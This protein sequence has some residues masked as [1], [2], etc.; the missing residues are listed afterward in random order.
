M[1]LL[2]GAA[3]LLAG[4]P[5]MA[6]SYTVREATLDGGGG[7]V[8]GGGFV[9]TSSL[10]PGPVGT[11]RGGPYVLYSAFPSPLAGQAAIVIVHSPG[12]TAAAGQP[13]DITARIIANTDALQS[14]TLYYGSAASAPTA[15]PMTEDGDGY[16]ATIP[17]SAI[18]EAGLTYYF[19]AVDQGGTRVRAPRQGVYGLPVQFAGDGLRKSTAQPAGTAQTAY[20]L[21]SMPVQLDDPRPQ[22]VLG[23]DL[24]TLAS[25]AAYDP[26]TAR[27]FEPVGTIVPEFPQTNNF[28]LGR[29]FW[30]IVRD[31]GV[32]LDSGPGTALSMEAPFTIPLDAGWTFI[33][34]PFPVSVPVENLSRADGAEVRLY[35]YGADGYNTLDDPVTEMQ[36]FE[37]YAVFA[38]AQTSLTVRPPAAQAGGRSVRRKAAEGQATV[39]WRLR[40]RATSAA[41]GD[42]NNVAAVHPEATD[43]WDAQ[44]WPEPPPIG[45]GLRLAF[46]APEG[47]PANVV[48]SAD[49]R[50]P[51]ARGLTWPLTLAADAAGPV[52]LTVDGLAQVPAAFDVWLLDLSTRDSWNLR[53]T[54]TARIDVLSDGAERSLR[55]VAGTDAYVQRTLRD[56]NVLPLQYALRPPNPHPST[57]P[58]AFQVGLPAAERVSIEVYNILGQRLAV[59]KDDEPMTPGFH[60]V[61]WEAPRL[62]SGVY[63][64]RM[65]AGTFRKTQK[66]VRVQ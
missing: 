16:V 39:P 65:T 23:D 57:G 3:L 58:V 28:R 55:L 12:G 51:S 7:R 43:G 40:L 5:A 14:A 61:V 31:A 21:L 48:L 53:T 6:Q 13:R 38:E 19:E 24:P 33:G 17:G 9:L 54:P 45:G 22:A 60:T 62:A 34:T 37:G 52:R 44:D 64:V 11:V 50:R 29:A 46:D 42:A 8:Q 4:T 26:A 32:T 1:A 18:G 25:A 47:A 15:Q 59:L 30:L 66:L 27:L 36:P 35:T 10:A 49:L 56:L 63:F 2:V 41:G 20:R